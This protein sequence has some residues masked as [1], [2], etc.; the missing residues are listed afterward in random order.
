MTKSSESPQKVPWL[1]PFEASRQWME[2]AGKA[3]KF[4]SQYVQQQADSGVF[5]PYNPQA[6]PQAFAEFFAS[7][8]KEP[9]KLAKAQSS[10]WEKHAELWQT[11]MN[12][13]ADKQDSSKKSKDRRSGAR[14]GRRT[15]PST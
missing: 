11:V 10:L 7:F 6:T 12:K 2:I 13:D 5:Q 14:N 4:V 15:S 1:D 3:Q 8:L 9:G